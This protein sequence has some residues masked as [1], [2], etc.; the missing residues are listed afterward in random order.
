[1]MVDTANKFT[2]KGKTYLVFHGDPF[3]RGS[4]DSYYGRPR[5]PH[6][7]GVGGQSGPRVDQL[8]AREVAEYHAGYDYNEEMGDKKYYY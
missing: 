2:Y 6:K 5:E 3:D 1:M 7:G 8:T 4:V